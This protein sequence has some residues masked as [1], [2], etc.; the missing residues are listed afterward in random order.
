MYNSRKCSVKEFV[1]WLQN[2]FLLLKKITILYLLSWLKGPMET[3]IPFSPWHLSSRCRPFLVSKVALCWEGI[4]K[5]QEGKR[6]S[7]SQL[8]PLC[9]LH[10]EPQ[11]ETKPLQHRWDTETNMTG[12]FCTRLWLPFSNQS[13][14]MLIKAGL[15]LTTEINIQ[16]P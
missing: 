9:F 10:Q 3:I 11:G 1:F 4:Y 13:K 8:E 12:S 6:K 2:D 16:H 5:L 7:T 14:T 15:C